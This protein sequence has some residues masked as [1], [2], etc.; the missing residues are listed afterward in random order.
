MTMPDPTNGIDGNGVDYAPRPIWP[1]ARLMWTGGAATAL[2]AA[3]I[4]LVGVLFTRGVLGIPVLAP[5]RA[6]VF[7]DSTT[8]TYAVSAAAAAFLA[9][10][11]LHLLLI[12][13]PSPFSFFGCIAALGTLGAVIGPLTRDALLDSKITAAVINLAVGVAVISLLSGVAHSALQRA[14]SRRPPG[15]HADGRGRW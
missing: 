15:S 9:T 13:V 5:E 12:A 2:V 3:L 11:L 1:D 10:A 14:G 6:G 8:I 4:V 7:G